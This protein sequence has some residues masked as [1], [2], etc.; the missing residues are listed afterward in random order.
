M[1]LTR[2]PATAGPAEGPTG[3]GH[4][5]LVWRRGVELVTLT[6]NADVE[7]SLS[8]AR[9]DRSERPSARRPSLYDTSEEGRHAT[10]LELFFDLVFVLAIAE[11]AHY[12]HDHLT[13]G[14]FLGFAF[15]FLPVWLVWS[16]D[17]W[18]PGR[19]PERK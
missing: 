9:G 17:T 6:V 13:V 16:G 3:C 7:H 1:G 14:G 19:I 2:E 10:W 15:L 11:L 8:A 4:R 5:A 12:L 18:S